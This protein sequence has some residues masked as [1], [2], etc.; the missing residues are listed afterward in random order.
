MSKAV[1]L[2][3][4]FGPMFSNKKVTELAMTRESRHRVRAPERVW[5]RAGDLARR[6]PP[7]GRR[8][9]LV[10]ALERWSTHCIQAATLPSDPAERAAG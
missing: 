4:T 5:R 7:P 9:D 8:A 1:G 3:K 2:V 6:S 10:T